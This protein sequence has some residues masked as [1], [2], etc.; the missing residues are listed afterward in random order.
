MGKAMLLVF[1][2]GNL[3]GPPAF[4]H[5]WRELAAEPIDAPEDWSGSMDVDSEDLPEDEEKHQGFD[6]PLDF[7]D[8]YES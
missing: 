8:G 6:D 4:H 7:V 1:A 2:V 3:W 5:G